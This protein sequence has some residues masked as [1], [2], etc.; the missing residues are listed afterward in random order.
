MA[1]VKC[2]HFWLQKLDGDADFVRAF[3]FDFRKAFDSVSDRVLCEKLVSYD[4]KNWI[5]SFLCD[6]QQRVVVDGVVTS[7]L[8][9]YR[10]VPQ[11]TV[12]GPFL[13]TIMVNG[14]KPVIPQTLLTNYADDITAREC[15]C[16]N[17]PQSH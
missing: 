16:D 11:G 2:Q 13:F 7:F 3:S 10:G 1:L 17:W 15:A 14:I 5:M 6:R 4:I 9:I 12:L 8:N